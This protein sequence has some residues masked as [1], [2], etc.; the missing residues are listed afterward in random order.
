VA[1]FLPTL[2]VLGLLGCTAAAFAVT[3][4][5]KLERS[6]I[7]DTQVGKV[8]APDSIANAKVGIG[9]VLRKPE[10]L[11]VEI[12]NGSGEVIRVIARDTARRPGAQSFTW[13]G[14]DDANR[15]V[16][17]GT[18]R[19]RVHLARERRTIVL[20]NPIR[21]DATP[22]FVRLVSVTPRTFSPD[23]DFRRETV[24]IQYQ[25]S[26]RAR[27]I[28]YVDGDR[29]TTVKRYVRA[30]KVDW[31]GRRARRLRP[32]PHR[33]RLRSEDFAGNL[34][35]PSRAVTVFVRFIE[36]RPHVQRVKTG[37][38]FGFR[39]VTD[40]KRYSVHLGRLH[41]VRSGPLLILRAPDPGRY[42]LRV[43]VNGR[44]AQ[45]LVVVR[46]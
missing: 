40:A 18:Y 25:T 8:I 35:A 31:G 29:R 4:G 42:T 26:E 30:G 12:V 36:L 22:P 24:R 43:A 9:F 28:V 1:R 6:P 10:R 3:E 45:A 27:A 33:V 41:V 38:R 34:G 44:V 14:R 32:G 16:P 2:L 37:R 15:P 17:D 5:L 46:P 13:D 39:V 23:G 20:P 11:T 21:M 19:P 7:G